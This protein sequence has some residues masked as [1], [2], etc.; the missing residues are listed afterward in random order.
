M[1]VNISS[2]S[3]VGAKEDFVPTY[4]FQE[5]LIQYQQCQYNFM[6]LLK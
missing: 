6:Q 4:I 2:S 5:E 3:R 1:M